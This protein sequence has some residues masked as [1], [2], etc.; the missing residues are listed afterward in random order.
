[1]EIEIQP[2]NTQT[3][4]PKV[5]NSSQQQKQ[6]NN[7]TGTAETNTDDSVKLSAKGQARSL[8]TEINQSDIT[9]T[10]SVVEAQEIV[11]QLAQTA[12]NDPVLAE[13]A[14]SNHVSSDQV[15][16]LLGQ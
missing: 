7:E 9:E 5:E 12:A 11:N 3:T 8:S 10:V 1:M 6:S 2:S 15:R 4:I 13:G 14:Q 16:R